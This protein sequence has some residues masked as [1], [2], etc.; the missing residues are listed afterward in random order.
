MLFKYGDIAQLGNHRLACGDSA[1]EGLVKKL[2]REDKIKSIV[3]DPPYGVDY[4][5]GKISFWRG[6]GQEEGEHK[7]I[8]ND[9]ITSDSNYFKFSSEWLEAIKSNLADKNSIYIFSA[10]KM[11]FPLRDAL[12][13]SG[14]H[15]GQLLIWIKNNS[16]L[17][18]LDYLPQHEM[19][20]YGWLGT[21][22]FKK[23]K[24]K[25]LLYCPKP[26]KSKLHPTMKPIPLL[27]RLILNSTSIGDYIFDG[28][29]GS[30][31]TLL[32]CEQT[33]R[34]CLMVELDSEYCEVICQRF[35]ALTGIKPEIIESLNI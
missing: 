28:F 10:D 5:S 6:I 19:I 15:F 21:H 18:R 7:P 14:F 25:S 30:G 27:R 8:K 24:D 17:G 2:V 29:G 26:N 11:L 20:I 22:E 16:V 4:V 1:D 23:S 13:A 9:A 33:E 32:A 31:S 34:K 35:E 12:L 3:S